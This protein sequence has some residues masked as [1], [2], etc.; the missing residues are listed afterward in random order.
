MLLVSWGFSSN[1]V[2]QLVAYTSG[3]SRYDSAASVMPRQVTSMSNCQPMPLPSPIRRTSLVALAITVCLGTA[4]PLVR[5]H[6]AAAQ[7]QRPICEHFRSQSDA[8]ATFTADPS[9]PF[10]LDD[11][12]NGV[13]CQGQDRFGTTS[14]VSCDDLRDSPAAQR[15]LQGLL[16]YTRAT[17]DP[18]ALDPDGNDIACDDV[19]AGDG[20]ADRAA[21]DGP[22]ERSRRDQKDRDGVSTD[23]RR[24]GAATDQRRDVQETQDRSAPVTS[25][26]PVVVVSTGARGPGETLEDR[27]EVRFAALEAQFDAFEVRAANGFG[28]FLEPGE[29]VTAREQAIIVIGSTSQRPIIMTQ[30][31]WAH[32]DPWIV[33]IQQANDSD[34]EHSKERKS[35]RN[36]HKEKHRHRR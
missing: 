1:P 2:W 19:E 35:K 28:R 7:D 27:L 26:A 15:A 22:P 11:D 25:R 20:R 17:G 12:N 9:D 29:H 3:A 31:T 24:N 36:R 5:V 8:Q 23:Q 33:R 16:D 34:G 18:Y 6:D 14:L 21:R 4:G 13:A 10:G 30:R 32:A